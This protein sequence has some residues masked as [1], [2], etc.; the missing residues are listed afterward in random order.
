[1]TDAVAAT[2]P[3][4]IEV[5]RRGAI[6]A[7]LLL[8]GGGYGLAQEMAPRPDEDLPPDIVAVLS[9]LSAI[10]IPRTGTREAGNPKDIEFMIRAL[11]AGTLGSSVE[12]FAQLLRRLNQ[13]GPRRFL[14]L[15]EEDRQQV[16]TQLDWAV[17]DTAAPLTDTG[18]PTLKALIIA[19]YYSSEEGASRE[20][21]YELVPGVYLPDVPVT[22]QSRAYASDWQG[23]RPVKIKAG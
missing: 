11:R 23:T 4:H 13:S 7:G 5:D 17:H 12:S 18:W 9:A 8:L 2:A 20:L 10:V 16:V 3:S 14:D 22:P 6:G 1:M 19:S 21:Q 15:A